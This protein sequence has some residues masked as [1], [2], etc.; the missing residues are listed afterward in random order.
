VDLV[1]QG[2]KRFIQELDELTDMLRGLS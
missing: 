1:T 2:I